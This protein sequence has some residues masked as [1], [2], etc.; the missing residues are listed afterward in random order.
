MKKQ[1]KIRAVMLDPP[2]NEQG[3]GK[4]K[5]GADRHYPLMKTRDIIEY[6]KNNV[7]PYLDD[8]CH[9]YL[10]VTNNFLE[11]GLKVL[12]ECGFRYITCIT[13]TKDKFGLGY[14]FRGQ[15]EQC[16]FAVKGKLPPKAKNVSTSITA[17]RTKHSKK[18]DEIYTVIQSVSPPPYA[19]V[20]ARSERK[21]WAA[22]GNEV[23]E[24]SFRSHKCLNK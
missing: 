10:W 23:S 1:K 13:W 3:G 2:W 19:E 12:K 15:T 18:P 20:F 6:V 8:N 5:R 7:N 4:I 24:G 9:I 21:G 14:Y 22:I 17:Q 11:D 16:L